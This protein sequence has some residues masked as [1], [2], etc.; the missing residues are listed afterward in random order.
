MTPTTIPAIPPMD[1]DDPEELESSL[2]SFGC[3]GPVIF[4][5]L[6]PEFVLLFVFDIIIVLFETV[7]ECVP[8][9]ADVVPFEVNISYVGLVCLSVMGMLIEVTTTHSAEEVSMTLI[10]SIFF[11]SMKIDRYCFFENNS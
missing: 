7:F 3:D 2:D 9:C 11:C 6:L 5:Y 4:G 1:N 8:A 10:D